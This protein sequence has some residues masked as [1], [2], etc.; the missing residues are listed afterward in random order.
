MLSLRILT[1]TSP[2]TPGEYENPEQDE[3]DRRA[4]FTQK[5]KISQE[6]CKDEEQYGTR[7][8]ESQPMTQIPACVLTEQTCQHGPHPN[9]PWDQGPGV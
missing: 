8:H 2:K 7:P 4:I 3:D 6:C 1:S 5:I 9:K